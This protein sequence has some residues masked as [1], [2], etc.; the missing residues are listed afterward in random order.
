[1]ARELGGGG[2]YGDSG[3]AA[4][5]RTRQ[6]GDADE[7]NKGSSTSWW[8]R[9]PSDLT[10]GPSISIWMPLGMCILRPV[11]HDG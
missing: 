2:A 10:G 1:M 4:V 7:A 9:C 3:V 8:L 5:A 6:R 11:G